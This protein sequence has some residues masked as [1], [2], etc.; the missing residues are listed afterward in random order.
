M[1]LLSA[2]GLLAAVSAMLATALAAP[3]GRRPR[4]SRDEARFA[5]VGFRVDGSHAATELELT[6]TPMSRYLPTVVASYQKALDR[7]AA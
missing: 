1:R 4:L 3:F 6:Y 7:F 2:L 5:R